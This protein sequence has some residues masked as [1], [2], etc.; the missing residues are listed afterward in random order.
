MTFCTP[1]S[2]RSKILW[3]TSTIHT[4]RLPKTASVQAKQYPDRDAVWSELTEG[5]LQIGPFAGE[6][7]PA[8]EHNEHY[9]TLGQF[10]GIPRF[11]LSSGS[12]NPKF[13]P[14]LLQAECSER[15]GDPEVKRRH[16]RLG[17]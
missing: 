8:T 6:K 4:G 1:T 14:V 15:V 2:S 11:P 9:R 17:D 3:I 10:A 5:G 13:E 7:Q 12:R 16:P